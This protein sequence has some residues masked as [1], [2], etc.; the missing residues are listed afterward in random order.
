MLAP[1]YVAAFLHDSTSNNTQQNYGPWNIPANTCVTR[2][3]IAGSVG[4]FFANGA[5]AAS[6]YTQSDFAYGVQ[7]GPTGYTPDTLNKASWET[8]NRWLVAQ[9]VVP[10]QIDEIL[11]ASTG[12]SIFDIFRYSLDIDVSPNRPASS[13]GDDLYFSFA[14]TGGPMSGAYF[15]VFGGVKIAYDQGFAP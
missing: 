10:P 12:A 9:G 1:Q 8:S 2:I 6:E 7:R 3:R 11:A 5:I 15:F 14:P 13:T 4:F